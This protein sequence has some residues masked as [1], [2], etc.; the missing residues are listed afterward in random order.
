MAPADA[1]GSSDVRFAPRFTLPPFAG[2]PNGVVAYLPYLMDQYCGMLLRI[3][4]H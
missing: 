2:N 3:W 1:R 4:W